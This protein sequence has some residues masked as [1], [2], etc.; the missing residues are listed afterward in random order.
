MLHLDWSNLRLVCRLGEERFE[1][2]SMQKEL[3]VLVDEKMD[4]SQQ[5]ELATWTDD[6][7][8]R[9]IEGDESDC[10]F[11]PLQRQNCCIQGCGPQ[12]RKD[13]ELL[14]QRKATKMSRG[15]EHLAYKDRL[16]ELA[17]FSLEKALGQPH[18]GLVVLKGSS[19]IQR[20]TDFL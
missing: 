11:L 20:V 15:L 18:C 4:I 9:C 5:Y 2:I 12:H 6:F 7:I 13:V 19:V 8:L 14:E 3:S 1:S 17:L 16:R 10:P